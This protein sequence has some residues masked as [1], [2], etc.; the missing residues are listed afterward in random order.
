MCLHPGMRR[1]PQHDLLL[2]PFWVGR[3]GDAFDETCR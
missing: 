1:T 2:D 3:R